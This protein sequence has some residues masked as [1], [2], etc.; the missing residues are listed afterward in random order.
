G[1]RGPARATSARRALARS[2]S[3]LLRLFAPFM[4]FVTEEVWSWWQEGSVHRASWPAASGVEGT[5]EAYSAC[6]ELLGDIRRTKSEAKVGPRAPVALV[7][8]EAP[9]DEVIAL[10]AALDDLKAAQNVAELALVP[11]ETRS[12]KVELAP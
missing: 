9:Q 3:T 11:G 1:E 8:L 12:V 7:H 6:I 2:L 10:A 4:P 5:G